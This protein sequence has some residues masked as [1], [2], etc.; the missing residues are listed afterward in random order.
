MTD[1]IRAAHLPDGSVVSSA[2]TTYVKDHPSETA[3]WR[4]TRGGQHEDWEVDKALTGG[5]EVLRVGDR[6]IQVVAGARWGNL[7]VPERAAL[8]AWTRGSA[9]TNGMLYAVR[10]ALAVER[11]AVGTPLAPDARE[12]LARHL[13]LTT[14]GD[15][16]A[17]PNWD[18]GG[19]QHVDRGPWLAK[20][21][22][23]LAIAR[24]GNG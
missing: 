3:A 24:G 7:T 20:A 6:S 4:G 16:H 1:Q 15:A 8:D 5:A 10:H 22:S 2:H 13:Y 12:R 17:Q 21:D 18:G 9:D 23:I 11:N 14:S 19:D